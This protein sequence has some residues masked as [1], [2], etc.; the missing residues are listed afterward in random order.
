MTC[1]C[2]H[3]ATVVTCIDIRQLSDLIRSHGI[4]ILLNWDGYSNNGVRA[5]GLFPVHAAPIQIAHQEYIGTM[6]ADD[7][8]QYLIADEVAVPRKYAQLYSEKVCPPQFANTICLNDCVCCRCSICRIHFL[9]TVLLTSVRI[10]LSPGWNMTPTTIRQRMHV[11]GRLQRHLSI[12]I[13][14]SISSLAQRYSQYGSVL[15]R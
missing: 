9:P 13:S 14:I 12:V 2:V 11:D 15:C 3:R 5:T 4:H 10:W 8:I 7:Y 6:G 1:V